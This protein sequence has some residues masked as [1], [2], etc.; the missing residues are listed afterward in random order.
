MDDDE[1]EVE[2]VNNFRRLYFVDT[3][4]NKTTGYRYASLNN[5]M[6]YVSELDEEPIA[7]EN[8][9]LTG[10][11]GGRTSSGLLAILVNK[12]CSV[13]VFSKKFL[14]FV[15]DNL[16]DDDYDRIIIGTNQDTVESI[17]DLSFKIFPKEMFDH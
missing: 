13:I 16:M 10:F 12:E 4:A 7:H 15:K 8:I 11:I 9:M 6:E 3:K 1:A 2:E 5:I 17:R 14:S